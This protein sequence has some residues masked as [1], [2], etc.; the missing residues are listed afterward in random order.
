MLF[1]KYLIG[2]V[3][4]LCI[5]KNVFMLSLTYNVYMKEGK[6]EME[7]KNI[8]RRDFLKGI[9]TTA[10]VLSTSGANA[11]D[12]KDSSSG[13]PT[14]SLKP[15][16]QK[17]LVKKYDHL[18]GGAL[19]GLSDNQL[20]AHFGLYEKYVNNINDIETKIKDYNL[21][22]PDTLTYRGLHV[23][24]TFNFNGVLLHEFYFG[25]LGPS[26]KEP[27]AL[28]K[29]MIER[30]FGNLQNFIE[31]LKTV[32]KVMRGWAVAG[33]NYRTGRLSVYGLDQHNQLTPSMIFP[34]LVLDVYEH[35][36]M[37]DYGTDRKKYLDAFVMNVDWKKVLERLELALSIPYGEG[38]TA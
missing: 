15:P 29:K 33:L 3:F 32:G 37:I 14:G 1:S 26:N 10:A 18:L 22:S 36:Y 12:K 27:K 11:Q 6:R 31:H 16:V 13:V 24:Q 8:D 23:E 19:K 17:Y 5:F 34:I 9:L 25:N 38:I 7:K 30:D 35:A 21:K 4:A 28:L 20:K 2:K